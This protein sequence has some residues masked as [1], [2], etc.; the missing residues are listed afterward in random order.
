M[1]SS[2]IMAAIL[3][4]P[5]K[6]LIFV[7]RVRKAERKLKRELTEEEKKEAEKKVIPLTAL[8]V[9]TFAFIFNK[10]LISQTFLSK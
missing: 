5:V 10:I 3:F 2:I 1:I 6:K 4:K 9:V 7:Q 8:I